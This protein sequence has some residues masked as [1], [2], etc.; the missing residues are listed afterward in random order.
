MKT[1]ISKGKSTAAPMK[2]RVTGK[3]TA[4]GGKSPM[5]RGGLVPHFANTKIVTRGG[6]KP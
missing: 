1:S 2:Q 5:G 6:K 3:G 4:R